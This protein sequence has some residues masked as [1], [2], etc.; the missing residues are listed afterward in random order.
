MNP[1]RVLF[2]GRSTLDVL[3]RLDRLPAE[4]QFGYSGSPIAVHRSQAAEWLFSQEK[5][6]FG[7]AGRSINIGEP[8]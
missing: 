2:V 1:P 8:L 4:V 5:T 3:Y 6:T 7:R